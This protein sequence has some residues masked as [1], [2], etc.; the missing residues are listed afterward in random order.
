M[1]L[2]VIFVPCFD[3]DA[4]DYLEIIAS[5]NPLVSFTQDPSTHR[6]CFMVNITDDEFLEDSENFNLVLSLV[7]GSSVPVDVMPPFSEV[8]I[9][10]N[11]CMTLSCYGRPGCVNFL[12]HLQLFLL[13]LIENSPQWLKMLVHMGCAFVSSLIQFSFHLMLALTFH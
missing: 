1:Y 3:I 11:D 7:E 12:V 5:N 8:E 13:D 10:D 4:D 6:Q 9:K 2:F